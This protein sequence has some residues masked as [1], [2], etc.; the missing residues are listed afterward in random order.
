MRKE[1]R[2]TRYYRFLL[3]LAVVVLVNMVGLNLFFR[4]DL[5]RD[6][7]Y[8]LSHAS[9]EAVSTLSEPL[10]INVFFTK[11]LPAP[12]NGIERYLRDLLEEY[13]IAGN[14][15]FN[16]RFYNVSAEEGEVSEEV[17]RNQQMARDYGIYPVQIQNIEEDEVKFQNAYMGM[18][19]VHG[20][21]IEKIPAITSTDGLEYQITS[22]I[23]RM[24]N[25]IS[26]FLNLKE[27]ISI[28]LFL[29]SS[30]QV[31]GPYMN[32]TG[33]G[34]VPEDVRK[35]VDRLNTKS[36][37]R[38]RFYNLDPTKD[39]ELEKEA[40][41]YGILKLRWR[42][43]TDSRGRVI[44][45]GY[46]YA[47]I[48]VEYAG[49]A[50]KLQ[51][52]QMVRLPLF[53][54]QYS[55]V[56][57]RT[58]EESI[59]GLVETLIEANE[60]IGY[61]ADH[62]TLSLPPPA[63]IG[64]MQ[65]EAE[66]ISNFVSLLSR[67]YSIKN[68]ML[69]DGGIPDDLQC[70][71]IAGPKEEFN[72]YELFQIDQFLM[73]GKSLAIFLDSF[74]EWRPG[75]TE[76]NPFMPNMEPI[77]KPLDTGLEKLLKHY[78]IAIKKSYVLDESSFMQRMHDRS[79]F[80]TRQI[81]Y[82]PIIKNE[83]INHEEASFLK[84]IKGLVMLKISPLMLNE[85]KIKD[86]H[87]KATLLFSSTEKAWE[88]SDKIDLNPMFINPPADDEKKSYPLAYLLEG[89]FKSYFADKPIPEKPV[90]EGKDE[91]GDAGNKKKKNDEKSAEITAE[92]GVIKEGRPGR[93]F[94]IGT[95]EVLKNA[96]I[97]GNGATPNAMFILNLI[98]YLNGR[99][100]YIEMRSKT[101]QFN[102]LEDISAASK[103]FVK[104]FNIAGLP[105]LM[106]LL[107]MIVWGRRANRKKVI[108]QQFRK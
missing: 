64:Q 76:G 4:I 56:D 22:L 7:R 68:V 6:N 107:G 100:D 36:Y 8:S 73:K 35:V 99:D 48:I 20:D 5:T 67:T 21:I 80:R 77:Y 50:E 40:E 17:R 33:L 96:M 87:L 65:P 83:F 103:V 92:G 31:V 101:Q 37:G 54:I 30:L 1:A 98:D 19:I 90:K 14:R 9:K 13:A 38:L 52:I 27:D 41:R 26:A 39:Q 2:Q 79:G 85:E 91:D 53:G 81:Y 102:P 66:S 82:A 25:K 61:L 63:F 42:S 16:Y 60:K 93:I 71:I 24:N 104:G 45:E 51:L 55:L 88:M 108:Q 23:R 15:Y 43:F 44:E 46:G 18:A 70:L 97:D 29:S 69:K 49:K 84:N 10:T 58:L 75:G 11:N 32:I 89:N 34:Q 47:G 94:I 86:N 62:K 106:I 78:G 12:Y 74:E 3:Y 105:I 28:K 57:M 72:D 95:S 59:E